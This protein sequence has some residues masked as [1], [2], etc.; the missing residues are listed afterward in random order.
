MVS[1]IHQFQSYQHGHRQTNEQTERELAVLSFFRMFSRREKIIMH[2]AMQ[3]IIPEYCTQHSDQSY[4]FVFQV[5]FHEDGSLLGYS[6]NPILI[7]ASIPEGRSV[8]SGYIYMIYPYAE[9]LCISHCNIIILCQKFRA[10]KG[11]VYCALFLD[12]FRLLYHDSSVWYVK[13]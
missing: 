1:M 2:N 8:C 12:G 10:L 3:I 11:V 9:V 13:L 6:G 5:A 4:G 7:D